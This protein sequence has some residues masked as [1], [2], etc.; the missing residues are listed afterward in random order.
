MPTPVRVIR[1]KIII[2][3]ICSTV[4]QYFVIENGPF[5]QCVH[6]MFRM[7]RFDDISRKIVLG[8]IVTKKVCPRL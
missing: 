6:V 5:Q 1:W 8:R 2:I 4:F 3:G 7:I